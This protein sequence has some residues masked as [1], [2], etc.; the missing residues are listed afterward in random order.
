[1]ICFKKNFIPFVLTG[2]SPENDLKRT[3]IG[4]GCTEGRS[5]DQLQARRRTLVDPPSLRT[6]DDRR[7]RHLQ[8]QG[9][10][11]SRKNDRGRRRIAE[12]RTHQV[13]FSEYLFLISGVV[14]QM[15]F[16]E[17]YTFYYIF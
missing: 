14:F 2:D 1:M 4:G 16:E 10:R 8:R 7:R 11:K 17:G 9:R 3:S 5:P 6:L 13:S 15:F 12:H